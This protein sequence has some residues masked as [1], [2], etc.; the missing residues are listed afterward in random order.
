MKLLAGLALAVSMSANADI[1]QNCIDFGELGKIIMTK[2][3]DGF[4]IG[5]LLEIAGREE[6]QAVA[7]I[8][9]KLVIEAY[10]VSHYNTPE[11][12]QKAISEFQNNIVVA[13]LQASS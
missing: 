9:R 13:C 5:K 6:N 3:Q 4:E 8:A 10:S 2:R 7:T 12:K 11:Y 1:T